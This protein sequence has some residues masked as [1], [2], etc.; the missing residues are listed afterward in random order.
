MYLEFGF[1]IGKGH[2]GLYCGIDT[3]TTLWTESRPAWID[4]AQNVTTAGHRNEA[5]YHPLDS[6]DMLRLIHC[7]HAPAPPAAA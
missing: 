7:R 1:V 2:P 3:F 4:P 5:E 6:S